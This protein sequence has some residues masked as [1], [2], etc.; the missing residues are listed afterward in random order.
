M[1]IIARSR[2]ELSLR[3]VTM[4]TRGDLHPELPLEGAGGKDLFTGALEQALAREEVDLCVHSLKDMAVEENELLPIAG[5][6]R[7]GDPRDMLI[8][9]K[10]PAAGNAGTYAEAAPAAALSLGR[11][12]LP[13]G[14]S[15]MRRR[16]Q[17]LA[18]APDTAVAP[19]RGNVL[20]RLA[21]L[22]QGQFGALILAA[23][24]IERLG[25]RDRPGY[26]FSVRDMVPA[27]GQGVLALQGRRGEDYAFLDALRDPLTEEEARAER[28]VILTLGGGCHFPAAAFARISG[29]EIAVIAMYA[30]GDASP[31]YVEEIAGPRDRGLAL[32]ETLARR[33]LSRGAAG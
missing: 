5:M 7:R 4:K 33:L 16:I 30:A 19:I 29:T 32:A 21:K 8:L 17:L 15:S 11:G 20:T 18:L 22:D 2:P 25:I 3:M 9:P 14:C 27:A 1:G 10:G 24:G 23:A 6:A 12:G 28:R 13:L 31:F 26:Y